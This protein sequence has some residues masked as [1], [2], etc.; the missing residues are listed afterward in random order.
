[1]VAGKAIV[2]TTDASI[3]GTVYH[4]GS[5]IYYKGPDEYLSIKYT[6]LQTHMSETPGDVANRGL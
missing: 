3:G 4:A 2:L 6:T 5:L 1:M